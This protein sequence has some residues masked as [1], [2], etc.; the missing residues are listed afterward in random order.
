M[1]ALSR[2]DMLDFSYVIVVACI[3]FWVLAWMFVRLEMVWARNGS[4]DLYWNFWSRVAGWQILAWVGYT[5]LF[6]II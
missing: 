4:L 3:N 1:S 2:Y 6:E 5:L